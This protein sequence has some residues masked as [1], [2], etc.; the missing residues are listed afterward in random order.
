MVQVI[1]QEMLEKAANR[2]PT[3]VSGCDRVGTFGLDM[4]EKSGNPVGIEIIK[5]QRG[6]GATL[7]LRDKLQQEFERIAVRADRMGARA[8]LAWQ[9]CSEERLHQGEQCLASRIAHRGWRECRRCCSKRTLA[10]SRS[11]GVALRYTSVPMTFR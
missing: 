2:G 5:S 9:I 4:I 10:S 7:M 1:A 3:A 6:D 11:C 8:S